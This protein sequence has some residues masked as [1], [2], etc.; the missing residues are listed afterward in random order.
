MI[1]DCFVPTPVSLVMENIQNEIRLTRK[2]LEL[3]LQQRR[4]DMNA[5]ENDHYIIYRSIG[6]EADEAKE[7]DWVQNKARFVYRSTATIVEKALLHAFISRCAGALSKVKI[8]NCAGVS[9]KT[10]EIDC[11]VGQ[12]AY[13]F[14][15]KDA[16]TD[17]DHIAKESARVKAVCDAGFRPIRLTMFQT[18]RSRA[19]C[20][21]ERMRHLYDSLGGLFLTGRE[22]WSHVESVTG[23]DVYAAIKNQ[24]GKL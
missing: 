5:D 15:W 7:L 8:N 2:K 21:Q 24:G 10:F 22:A 23:V 9:P 19:I 4:Q 16:T 11:A 13:E 17:G 6:I 12:N 1:N 18:E 3:S 20:I 14:K